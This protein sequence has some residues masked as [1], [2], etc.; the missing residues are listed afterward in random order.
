MPRAID[1][2]V[3]LP[4]ASF[5]EGAIGPYRTA[6]ERFFRTSVPVRT[7]DEVARYY[8]ELDMIGVLLAWDAETATG[9]PPVTNDEV[10]EIVRR[11][12]DRFIGFASVDPWKGR[13]A[14]AEIERAIV[15][16]GLKG[17]KFHPSIQAFSPHDP[18]FYPLYEKISALG[19]PALFHTGTSGL[20]AGLP[21][22][23]GV[24]LEYARPIHLD[25]VAADFPDLV[26]IGAHTGWPWHEEL[27]AIIG[28]KP[29]V[30]MDLSG[31]S[32]RYI[33]SSVIEAAR[34][35]L[36]DRML[37]GSDYPFI[38]PERWLA[39]FEALDGFSPDVRR[40]ILYENA[41]RVLKLAE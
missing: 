22:G 18:R 11:Y 23:G 8:E 13:R 39:D 2:H 33:P 38:T 27:L 16:L 15:D 35:R 25:A 10:A 24:K 3:H 1:M 36:S 21:G 20:G 37:F 30:Y 26:I 17:V 41:A 34:K 40:K 9:C 5:L 7:L 32:P 4:T 12:P 29:N 14:L 6:A 19:V 28:H 31:W